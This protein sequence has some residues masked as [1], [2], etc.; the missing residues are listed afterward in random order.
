[1]EVLANNQPF[2]FVFDSV[3]LAEA[4][5]SFDVNIVLILGEVFEDVADFDPGFG[6]GFLD[7]GEVGDVGLDE[8]LDLR[9]SALGG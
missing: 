3:V 1:M 5:V 4:M 8:S 7:V 6:D 9:K 2:S